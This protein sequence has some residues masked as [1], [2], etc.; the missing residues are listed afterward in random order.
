MSLYAF[1]M[2]EY[3]QMTVVYWLF[4]DF[5]KIL[6][7]YIANWKI[8]GKHFVS[9]SGTFSVKYLFRFWFSGYYV[10]SLFS[11]GYTSSFVSLFLK[12]PN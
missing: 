3:G 10:V 12:K 11:A 6:F 9:L 8:Y 2:N 1:E 4:R 5:F 7:L